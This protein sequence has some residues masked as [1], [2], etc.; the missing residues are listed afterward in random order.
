MN[1]KILENVALLK[2]ISDGVS[3]GWALAEEL[4]KHMYPVMFNRWVVVGVA[5]RWGNSWVG[6]CGN[7]RREMGEKGRG[8]RSIWVVE[9]VVVC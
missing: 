9:E 8:S 6:V 5:G 2:H 3:G 4:I 7:S 1:E